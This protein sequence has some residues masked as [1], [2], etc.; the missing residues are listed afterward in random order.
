MKK[1]HSADEKASTRDRESF[2]QNVETCD[3]VIFAGTSGIVCYNQ[4]LT[5][6]RPFTASYNWRRRRRHVFAI[7][8]LHFSAGSGFIFCW[9][10]RI[11]LLQTVT[12][13]ELLLEPAIRFAG[14]R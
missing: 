11:F 9:N 7:T 1:L 3:D 6:L 13:A 12:F 14:K 4:R 5:L 2:N 10:R 8:A